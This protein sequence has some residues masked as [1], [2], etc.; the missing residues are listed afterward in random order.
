MCF[1]FFCSDKRSYSTQYLLKSDF[2]LLLI[3]S[4]VISNPAYWTNISFV[5]SCI[6]TVLQWVSVP[7]IQPVVDTVHISFW[8]GKSTVKPV[9]I[10]FRLPTHENI[11]NCTEYMCCIHCRGSH[12]IK[13]PLLGCNVTIMS[14]QRRI[15]KK[16][17]CC[18]VVPLWHYWQRPVIT[19]LLNVNDEMHGVISRIK[20]CLRWIQVPALLFYRLERPLFLLAV[21]SDFF[22]LCSLGFEF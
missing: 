12:C 18:I 7:A 21:F 6:I 19:S 13:T 3:P 14:W 10:I 1:V 22:Q 2:L 15:H 4:N 20:I 5:L 17:S 16:I 9:P 11:N 8:R